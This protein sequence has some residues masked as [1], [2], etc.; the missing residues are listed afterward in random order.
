[1]NHREGQAAGSKQGP[2]GT[3]AST[4]SELHQQGLQY[5]QAGRYLDAHVCCQRALALSPDHADS[6]HLAGRLAL[7]SGQADAALEWISRAIQKA[8]TAEYL[9]ALG[10]ALQRLGR[11]QEALQAFD[12]AAAHKPDVSNWKNLANLLFELQQAAP[13]LQAYRHVLDL[14]PRDWDAACRSGY[15]HYQSGHLEEALTHFGVCDQVRPNHAPT[16]YMRS[17]FLIG[18]R[19]F[20]EAIAEARRAQALDP[21]NADTCNNIGIAYQALQR[22]QEALPWFEKALE[23]R[24][25]FD[26]ALFN[27]TVSLAK[28]G[29][30]DEALAA[31]R[32]MKSIRGKSSAITDLQIAELL[33]ELGHREE[34]LAILDRCDKANPNHAPTLQLRAVCLRGLKQLE[35][36]LA[37]SRR[38]HAIHPS[39][40]GICSNIGV[41]LNELGRCQEALPWLAKATAM[42]P[43]NLDTLNNLADTQAQLGQFTEAIAT[44]DRVRAIDQDNANAA[45]GAAHLD[46]LNGNFEAGWAGREARW[47]VAGLPIVYPRF[48]QPMWLGQHDI[49]G[50]TILIYADE[51]MGDAIQL[52]RY[53]PMLAA[54][55]AKVVLAVHRPLV[56][57]LSGVA[58]VAQCV[59]NNSAEALPPFDTYC[60]MLSLPLAFATRLETIPAEIPYLPLPSAEAVKAWDT[61]LPAHDRLRI[62]LVWSGNP[63]HAGD[64]KRSIPLG[65]LT[66]ILDVDVTFVSLQ[67]ELRAD[68]SRILESTDIVDLT[69]QL[70][71]FSET[72]ALLCCLDLVI[73]V[74]TSVAHL[75]G[76]L[77]RPAWVLLPNSPDYRWL[78]GRDDSPWYPTLR[79]FRQSETREYG[80][81]LDRVRAELLTLLHSKAS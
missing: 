26:V 21:S 30:F 76:A 15:L 24:S 20:E 49:A 58:G 13:A 5:L 61:R 81:V 34:A 75:A 16:L 44:Y 25:A 62:G 50:K 60:P 46:L 28:L 32:H 53:V 9:P 64:I 10:T 39:N 47:K 23:L 3:A 70:T 12:K 73:T 54:L 1:M 74:D 40:A 35:R 42:Q 33:M 48:S 4:P 71:D 63:N 56:P 45:L 18:L 7:E 57:L 43:D 72:A 27:K 67:K 55:G 29:R 31:Y 52:A 17:V 2:S 80:S 19:R 69:A 65:L 38:A 51:G 36:S 14:D 77:G 59:V 68:D 79:L 66:R 37:D 41:V 6:L 22:H 11:H 78:L 8:P